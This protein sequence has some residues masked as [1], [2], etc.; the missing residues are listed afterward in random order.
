MDFLSRNL[1]ASFPV[2]SCKNGKLSGYAQ[3]ITKAQQYKMVTI[4]MQ[5]FASEI[6]FLD[7][8]N[9][10][11]TESLLSIEIKGRDMMR[12]CFYAFSYS[13]RL[14]WL[15]KANFSPR[16]TAS[17]TKDRIMS[18]LQEAHGYILM[19]LCLKLLV[20]VHRAPHLL[21]CRALEVQGVRLRTRTPR[22]CSTL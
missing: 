12:P 2:T 5:C 16:Y 22:I 8:E 13:F 3:P 10:F 15:F 21:C 7:S 14:Y 17:P 9:R 11:F 18:F 1:S 20:S 4:N 6:V 19:Q